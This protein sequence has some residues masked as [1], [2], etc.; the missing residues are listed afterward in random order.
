MFCFVDRSSIEMYFCLMFRTEKEECLCDFPV[1][2]IKQNQYVLN[3]LYQFGNP[4]AENEEELENVTFM[5]LGKKLCEECLCVLFNISNWRY[6]R[7]KDFY[8][9]SK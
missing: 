7:V 8:R 6:Q 3:L 5:L 9:V 4:S 1:E 2:I